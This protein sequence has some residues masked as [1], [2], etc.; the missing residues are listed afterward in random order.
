MRITHVI[1]SLSYGG[2]ETMLVDIL[3]EQIKYADVSLIVVNDIYSEELLSNIDEKVVVKKICR[4]AGSRS[5]LPFLKFN[6]FLLLLKPNII[7]CH[8]HDLIKIVMFHKSQCVLT[9]HNLR[10][11]VKY[12]TKYRK[13]FAISKAVK[14]DLSDRC[15]VES[16]LVY[17]G[18][19]INRIL[20]KKEQSIRKTDVFEILQIGRLKHEIKGQDIALEAMN[21]IVNAFHMEG[22]KLSFIG[23]GNS[24]A[25][26]KRQV[27][28]L[29]LSN[30]VKFMGAQSRQATYEMIRNYDLL[31]QPSKIEG[32]GLTIV[33]GMAA[34]VPVLV[35]NIDG[36]ME[37]IAGGSYGSYFTSEDAMSLASA[38]KTMYELDNRV[39]SQEKITD[40]YQHVL[41]NFDIKETAKRYYFEYQ[42]S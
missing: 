29:G 3:N 2:S 7:H 37:V 28:E 16:V 11:P 33:E 27:V 35:S 38:I 31:I 40:A 8:V 18:V 30:F 15:G 1:W 34:K 42:T 19:H 21:I 10:A 23:D 5:F 39:I 14:K 6:F 22:I 4:K 12:L 9:I 36:P 20:V 13:I 26:L 32:F 41:L 25:F 24:E 17:N